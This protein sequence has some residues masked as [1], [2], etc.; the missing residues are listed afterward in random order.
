[1]V[2]DVPAQLDKLFIIQCFWYFLPMGVANMSPVL[3]KKW[4][5]ELVYPLDFKRQI[6]G[7]PI[8]GSHKTFRGFL[9]V[10]VIGMLVFS[11]QQYLFQF[12]F[13]QKISLINYNDYNLILGFTLA[14]G[15]SLGDLVKS[16]FKRRFKIKPGQRW[17]PFDQIDYVLGGLL[18]SSLIYL[19]PL[20]VWITL[21]ILGFILHILV[22]RIG[23]WFKVQEVKW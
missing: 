21:G 16:F 14:L 4:F 17:I 8:L 15:A 13:F 22:N 3:F 10:V 12:S 18:L 20:S 5:K 23:Y 7:N 6:A 2:F 9:L 19:P 11:L 1:M